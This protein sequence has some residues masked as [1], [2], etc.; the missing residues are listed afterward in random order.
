MP[1]LATIEEIQVMVD[2]VSSRQQTLELAIVLKDWRLARIQDVAQQMDTDIRECLEQ[3]YDSQT[4]LKWMMN[5]VNDLKMVLSLE[6]MTPDE[7]DELFKVDNPRKDCPECHG[8]GIVVI[9]G[10]DNNYGN[11]YSMDCPNCDG[12]GWVLDKGNGNG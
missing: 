9:V 4:I 6:Q 2:K 8:K 11:G 12:L 7:Y 3:G 10:N 1:T 5:H